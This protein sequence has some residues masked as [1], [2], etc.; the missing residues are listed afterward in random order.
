MI[1][2]TVIAFLFSLSFLIF[3]HEFFHFILAKKLKVKVEEF[4]IGLP[5]RIFSKKIGETIYSIGLLPLGGFN[6]LY[7]EEKREKKPGSFWG[8]RV[9]ERFLIVFSAPLANFLFGA[10]LFSI[11]FTLGFPQIIEKKP[12]LNAK[13]ISIQVIQVMRDSPADKAGIFLGDKIIALKAKKEEIKNIKEIEEIQKFI[14]KHK[15]EKIELT[16]KRGEKMIKKVVIA[17]KNPPKGEGPLGIALA[18]TAIVSYP[19]PEAIIKGG[20]YCLKISETLFLVLGKMIKGLFTGEKIQGVE[21]VGPIGIGVLISQMI[22]QGSIYF[23]HFLGLLSVNLAL[24][25]LLPLPALDGGKIMLL[26][27]EKI[28]KKPLSERAENLINQIGIGF[29]IFLM[30]IVTIKDLIRLF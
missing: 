9:E 10:F 19:F 8:K 14:E 17:R 16:L 18:K 2:L 7:G 15:G 11:V 20:E 25:N 13:E 21:I 30:I 29:L 6:K 1:F 23:L 12:P 22:S 27:L 5:P 26:F 3:L 24:F 4:C 28:R